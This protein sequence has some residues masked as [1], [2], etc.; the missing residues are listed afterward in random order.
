[1]YRLLEKNIEELDR[2][3]LGQLIAELAQDR[4]D[5]PLQE[6]LIGLLQQYHDG[7][8]RKHETTDL[9]HVIRT[10]LAVIKKNKEEELRAILKLEKEEETRESEMEDAIQCPHCTHFTQKNNRFCSNCGRELYNLM[11]KVCP[12]CNGLNTHAATYCMHCGKLFDKHEQIEGTIEC[13]FCGK[14]AKGGIGEKSARV[15]CP[16]CG[17]E[18]GGSKEQYEIL[19]TS[20]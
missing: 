8:V 3:E 5:D 11:D 13:P 1:M 18:W 15:D 19:V 14:E 20:L 17:A 10:L 2:A 6:K 4:E 12:R 9:N 16:H 7:K